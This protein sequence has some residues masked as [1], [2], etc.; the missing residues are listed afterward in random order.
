MRH[1][2]QVPVSSPAL[3]WSKFEKNLDFFKAIW[4]NIIVDVCNLLGV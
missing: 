2:N 3:K 1:N 4:L